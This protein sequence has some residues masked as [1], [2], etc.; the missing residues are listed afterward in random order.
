MQFSP[1]PLPP[2]ATDFP[3]S[4][5]LLFFGWRIWW[6]DDGVD[7]LLRL[8]RRFFA[9]KVMCF[10]FR[11]CTLAERA[12]SSVNAMEIIVYNMKNKLLWRIDE[13]VDVSNHENWNIFY[14]QKCIKYS[15]WVSFEGMRHKRSTQCFKFQIYLYKPEKIWNIF[16]VYI[17]ARTV[18]FFSLT[19]QFDTIFFFCATNTWCYDSL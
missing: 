12:R 9:A 7:V 16:V 10:V 14:L 1:W 11:I 3:T 18:E 13:I 6:C 17:T 19:L 2:N 4:G 8:G 5:S 15:K